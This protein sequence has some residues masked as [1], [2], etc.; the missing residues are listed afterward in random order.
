MSKDI[1][2]PIAMGEWSLWRDGEH[3]GVRSSAFPPMVN[4]VMRHGV[5]Y[6]R[7]K[8]RQWDTAQDRHPRLSI[9]IEE[10]HE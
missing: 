7:V 9:H 1:F 3:L 8:L 10:L 4:D 5:D 6:Y 2:A